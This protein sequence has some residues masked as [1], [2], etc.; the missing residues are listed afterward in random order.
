LD[1]SCVLAASNPP[2]YNYFVKF[3]LAQTGGRELIPDNWAL[4]LD[5]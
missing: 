5:F 3:S 2:Y 4:K 1:V